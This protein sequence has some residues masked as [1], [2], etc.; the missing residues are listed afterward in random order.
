[1]KSTRKCSWHLNLLHCTL[2]TW[3]QAAQILKTEHAHDHVL[4]VGTVAKRVLPRM[5]VFYV[6]HFR[7][8]VYII[9]PEYFDVEPWKNE[10]VHVY[11]LLCAEVYKEGTTISPC[12]LEIWSAT[13]LSILDSITIAHDR[14]FLGRFVSAVLP[15][16]SEQ[17]AAKTWIH[18]RTLCSD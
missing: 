11:G 14:P 10:T 9:T 16:A 7:N 1:M 5:C 18:S 15:L 12:F 2:T 17:T 6:N 13:F 4:I 3:P 8:H